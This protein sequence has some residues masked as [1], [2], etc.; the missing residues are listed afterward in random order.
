MEWTKAIEYERESRKREKRGEVSDDE[1]RFSLIVVKRPVSFKAHK[2][3]GR[4]YIEQ[5]LVDKALEEFLKAVDL[6]PNDPDSYL[7]L[8]KIYHQKAEIN[9]KYVEKAIFYYEMYLY[10]GG[11]E[12]AEV[13]DSLKLL[14]K[15]DNK[16]L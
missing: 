13:K 9:R 4:L 8:G 7:E 3:L 10:L 2:S 15:K 16:V 1:L 6:E 12:E 5:N 14:K 11:K